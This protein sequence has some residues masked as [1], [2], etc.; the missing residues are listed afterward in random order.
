MKEW[1]NHDVSGGKCCEFLPGSSAISA[2][3]TQQSATALQKIMPKRQV[4]SQLSNKSTLGILGIFKKMAHSIKAL[5]YV[6]YS[7]KIIKY[8]G[9]IIILEVLE[10]NTGRLLQMIE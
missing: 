8:V 6:V 4:T 2:L 1:Q 3:F 7:Y 5:I 10:M 9:S